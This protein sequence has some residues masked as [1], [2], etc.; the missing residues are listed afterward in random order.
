MEGIPTV[1]G[2]TSGETVKAPK[3]QIPE[4]I[5]EASLRQKDRVRSY[6]MYE[7]QRSNP[8]DLTFSI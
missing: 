3:G 2:R 6:N 8:A 1:S 4:N 7:F 5:R